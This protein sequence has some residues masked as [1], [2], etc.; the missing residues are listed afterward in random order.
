MA[1]SAPP[2]GCLGANLGIDLVVSFALP[3]MRST[4][5]H[6]LNMSTFLRLLGRSGDML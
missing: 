3:T 5:A 2:S 4:L 6:T 1:D